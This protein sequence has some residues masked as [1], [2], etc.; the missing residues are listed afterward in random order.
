VPVENLHSQSR[1][2]LTAS[3]AHIFSGLTS[4]SR[5]K[6]T[7]SDLRRLC[8]RSRRSLPAQGYPVLIASSAAKHK[9]NSIEQSID[10]WNRPRKMMN[11]PVTHKYTTD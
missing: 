7:F 10:I 5:S 6:R 3:T 4:A 9:N 11:Q 1:L 2:F 8:A